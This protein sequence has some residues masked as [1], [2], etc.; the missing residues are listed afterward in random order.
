[1]QWI[2]SNDADEHVEG[3]RPYVELGFRHLVFHM[4]GSDQERFIQLYSEVRVAQTEKGLRLTLK[5]DQPSPVQRDIWAVV[6]IKEL[7]AAKQRLAGLLDATL[8]RE[9][10]EVMVGEV[11]EAL[12]GA[13]ARGRDHRGDARSDGDPA[14]RTRLGRASSPTAPG[15]VKQPASPLD[16]RSSL[17]KDAPVML[18]FARRYSRASPRPRSTR[19]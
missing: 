12:A 11:L 8:R 7:D 18:T 3:I 13:A 16:R 4:P 19:F 6:P 14:R 17:A 15:A 1:M 2:V 10:A 9:L 5:G